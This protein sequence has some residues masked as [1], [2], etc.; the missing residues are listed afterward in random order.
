MTATAVLPPATAGPV[1]L[2]RDAGRTGV[3]PGTR[4]AGATVVR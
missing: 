1:G 4:T 2:V 3:A